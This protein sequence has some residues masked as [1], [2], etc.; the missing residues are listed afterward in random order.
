MQVHLAA[1][2]L[3]LGLAVGPSVCTR[4]PT[5]ST[6]SRQWPGA[7]VRPEPALRQPLQAT[8]LRGPRLGTYTMALTPRQ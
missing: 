2:T 7:R 1:D 3:G 6:E 4:Q 5:S 8:G